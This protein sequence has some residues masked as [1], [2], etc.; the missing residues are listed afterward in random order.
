MSVKLL[1]RSPV[2][3]N[4][5]ILSSVSNIKKNDT[6]LKKIT[7]KRIY[8]FLTTF[9]YWEKTLH[10]KNNNNNKI[11]YV[12]FKRKGHLNFCNS[13]ISY[14]KKK[15]Q[16]SHLLEEPP[17]FFSKMNI[18]LKD[19]RLKVFSI[20]IY[21]IVLWFKVKQSP[22]IKEIENST[23]TIGG[24]CGLWSVDLNLACGI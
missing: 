4:L 22:R 20:L 9:F 8:C 24:V 7:N 21:N 19:M 14:W 5:H 10:K 15:P 13:K 18:F 16:V 11:I 3:F 1:S 2:S 17:K 12:I 6:S 23:N